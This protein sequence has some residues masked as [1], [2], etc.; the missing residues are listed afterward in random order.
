MA[1]QQTGGINSAGKTSSA[2]AGA[3]HEA[4]PV[5]P[6]AHACAPGAHGHAW[7]DVEHWRVRV[8][9]LG[10]ADEPVSGRVLEM[11]PHPLIALL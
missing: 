4:A 1:A 8:R 5:R 11:C 7:A 10:R 2:E 3:A 9:V 6:P